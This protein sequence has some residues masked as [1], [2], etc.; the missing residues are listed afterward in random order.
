MHHL[1]NSLLLLGSLV[2]KE[3]LNHPGYFSFAWIGPCLPYNNF[4]LLFD[5]LLLDRVKVE[6]VD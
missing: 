6:V 2:F 1:L 5:L 4:F 3:L